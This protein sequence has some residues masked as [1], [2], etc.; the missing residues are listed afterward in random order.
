MVHRVVT[1]GKVGVEGGGL[2]LEEFL[3]VLLEDINA[4]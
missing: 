4:S 1:K 3:T 2:V